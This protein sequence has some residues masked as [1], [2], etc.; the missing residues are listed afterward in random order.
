[1]PKSNG[2]RPVNKTDGPKKRGKKQMTKSRRADAR[3]EEQGFDWAAFFDN[4][5][6]SL[7]DLWIIDH[8]FNHNDD[9]WL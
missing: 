7:L 9:D 8:L 1:M 5:M 2:N 4:V 6:E 3:K